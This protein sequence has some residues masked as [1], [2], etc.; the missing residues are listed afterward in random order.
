MVLVTATAGFEHGSRRARGEEFEVSLHQA[1]ALKGKGLVSFAEE[2]ADP[3]G[4]AGEK[5]SASPAAPASPQTTA[6]RSGRGAGAAK[7]SGA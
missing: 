7:A 3:K 2:K 6:E 4:A 5:S 1:R